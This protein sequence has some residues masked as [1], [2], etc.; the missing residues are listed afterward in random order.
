MPFSVSSSNAVQV[1]SRYS[2]VESPKCG[3]ISNCTMESNLCSAN[4]MISAIDLL[5]D[6]LH[7]IVCT[8]LGGKLLRNLYKIEKWIN[9]SY[10]F[11]PHIN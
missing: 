5:S 10:L 6:G 3:R 9:I 2:E 7:R 8:E 1:A 4:R 11:L